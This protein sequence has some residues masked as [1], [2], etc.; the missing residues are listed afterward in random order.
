MNNP[1][2]ASAMSVTASAVMVVA[3][4]VLLVAG[5]STV[6][7]SFSELSKHVEAHPE[8]TVLGLLPPPAAGDANTVQ[9]RIQSKDKAV[10]M[11]VSVPAHA[12]NQVGLAAGDTIRADSGARAVTFKKGGTV[13]AVVPD[14]AVAA[15]K[16]TRKD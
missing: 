9:A 11:V 5:S 4:P 6:I 8:W 7:A 16:T 10:T 3:S 13:L 14:T 2:A 1:S 15:R 12:I